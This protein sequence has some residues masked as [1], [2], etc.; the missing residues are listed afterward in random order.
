MSKKIFL[1]QILNSMFLIIFVVLFSC[2]ENTT[3]P[4]KDTQ[5]P[6]VSIFSP[7]TNSVLTDT[8]TIQVNATDNS[9]IS[10]VEFYID[11][12]KQTGA[13]DLTE[14]FEYFWDLS[15]S[16]IG[17]I[18]TLFVKAYDE[19]GNIGIS[20]TIKIYYKWILLLQDDNET[21]PRDIDKLFVRSS[22][23]NLEFRVEMNDNWDNPH[24]IEGG[25]DCA[26][27]L[28]TDQNPNT[29]LKPDT[30]YWHYQVNDIG[31]DF[32]GIIG[33]E[34]DSLWNWNSADTTWDKFE[35]FNYLNISN[36]SN[37]FEVGINLIDLGNPTNINIVSANLTVETDSTYW[38]WA[39]NE[40]HL[41]YEI[42]G[43][44]FGKS[45]IQLNK[46]QFIQPIYE[47]KNQ[48]YFRSKK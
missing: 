39:P 16:T 7:V 3:E 30:T 46:S 29:G 2:S 15:G 47:K 28:D 9:N 21:F 26:L 10:K 25:I 24:N 4:D 14:P 12:V 27:F 1:N 36:N 38:D 20:D 17:D 43:L 18:H 6:D 5:I 31:A 34:G 44:Y 48:Y 40:N 41:T 19:V 37:F 23:T 22:T 11:N 35:D 33:F 45:N 13:D 42:D 32:V 8:V